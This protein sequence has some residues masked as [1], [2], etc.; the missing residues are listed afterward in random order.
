MMLWY[1]GRVYLPKSATEAMDQSYNEKVT[2]EF[3]KPTV[4]LEDGKPVATV[5]R[6]T[7]SYS[8]TLDLIVQES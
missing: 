6:M 1:L 4:V 8:L 7:L 2:D 5:E 3:V